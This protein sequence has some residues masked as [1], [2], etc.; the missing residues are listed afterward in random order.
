MDHGIANFPQDGDHSDQLIHVA[1]ERLYQLKHANHSRASESA[2]RT[3]PPPL[4]V[5]EPIPITTG[6][7]AEKPAASDFERP[8]PQP[9]NPSR[10]KPYRTPPVPPSTPC[11]EKPNASP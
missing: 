6:R 3:A 11:S 9:R 8:P 4:A 10:A 1:D 5:Q 2:P 7:P